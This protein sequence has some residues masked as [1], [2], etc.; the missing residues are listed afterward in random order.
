MKCKE[1]GEELSTV[2][3]PCMK[4]RLKCPKGLLSLGKEAEEEHHSAKHSSGKHNSWQ[5]RD[6]SSREVAATTRAGA[7]RSAC[8][9]GRS[10][11]AGSSLCRGELVSARCANLIGKCTGA[12]R[13]GLDVSI[14]SGLLQALNDGHQVLSGAHLPGSG[15]HDVDGNVDSQLVKIVGEHNVA[16]GERGS[17]LDD[18]LERVY[19]LSG[20]DNTGSDSPVVGVVGLTSGGRGP[21]DRS[22]THLE[23]DG[24]HTVVNVTVRRT[25]GVG[26]NANH[27][28]NHLLGPAKFG[29]DLLVGERGERAVRPGVDGNLVTLLELVLDHLGTRDDNASPRQRRW[30]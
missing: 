22:E 14:R 17:V 26:S 12:V 18:R 10:K 7:A 24:T 20:R 2:G 1:V 15:K 9:G 25:H 28:A 13:V 3:E 21:D 4:R 29:N 16:G 30:T 27:A 19:H 8:A 23:R 5:R 6:G 11:R